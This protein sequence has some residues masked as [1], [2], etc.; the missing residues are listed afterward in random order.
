[1][2]ARHA[3]GSGRA[4]VEQEP[5]ALRGLVQAALEDLGVGPERQHLAVGAGQVDVRRKRLVSHRVISSTGP[6]AG[7]GGAL[8]IGAG[9]D[10]CAAAVPP[11]L[12]SG[13]CSDARSL[14]LRSVL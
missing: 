13:Y 2:G 3:V 6:T 14:V 4:L 1:V 12:T 8:T 11:L 5:R 10:S 7:Q 9:D